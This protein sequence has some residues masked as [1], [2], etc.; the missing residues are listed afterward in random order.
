MKGRAPGVAALASETYVSLA[1]YRRDGRE[2]KTPV[3]VVADP[4]DATRLLV[5]TNARSGKVKRIRHTPG[6]RIAPC[7]ARG[8]VSGGVRWWEARAHIVDDHT[9]SQRCFDALIAKYGWQARLLFVG[10]RI[11]GR[12]K[13]RCVLEV[14]EAAV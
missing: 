6:V 3:W 9:V 5:Y 10:A 2:V 12:W 14:R 11:G 4:A 1:T 8:G 7:D 13:D